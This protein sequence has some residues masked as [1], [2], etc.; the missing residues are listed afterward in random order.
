MHFFLFTL[1]SHMVELVYV[2]FLR[3]STRARALKLPHSP[4]KIFFSI[5]PELS[6]DFSSIVSNSLN[7]THVVFVRCSSADKSARG[8]FQWRKISSSEKLQKL[9][10]MVQRKSVW[11]IKNKSSALSFPPVLIYQQ[12]R[13]SQLKKR[14]QKFILKFFLCAKWKKKI[15]HFFLDRFLSVSKHRFVGESIQKSNV[16]RSWI[17]LSF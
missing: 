15:F 11:K 17:G 2:A 6:V 16:A 7:V 12:F 3:R 9:Q 5:P 13:F 1:H 14:Y 10:R 4:A 8:E